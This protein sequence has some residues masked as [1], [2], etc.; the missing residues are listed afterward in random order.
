MHLDSLL[1]PTIENLDNFPNAHLWRPPLSTQ[2]RY[3]LFIET[4]SR[5]RLYRLGAE[6]PTWSQHP[7]KFSGHKPC[8]NGDIDFSKLSRDLILDKWSESCGFKGGSLLQ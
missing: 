2:K 8:E 4:R 3:A 1:K 7:A 5:W 6:P